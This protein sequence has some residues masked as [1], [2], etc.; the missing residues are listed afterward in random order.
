MHSFAS[1]FTLPL[2]NPVLIFA[3]VLLIILFAPIIF[4]RLRI[5]Y[6][7]GLIVAGIIVGPNGFNVLLHDSSIELFGTVGLLYIM[8][9]AGVEVDIDDFK[10]NRFK[11]IGY[12]LYAFVIA[13]GIGIV[14]ALY[15]LKFDLITSVLLASMFSSHTLLAYPIVSRYGITKIRAVSITVI[16]TIIT[17]TLSLLTLAVVVGS[18]DGNLDALHWV[19]FIGQFLLFS[20]AILFGFPWVTRQFFKR[21][22]DSVA[23]YIFVLAMLFIAAFGAQ[24][25]GMEGI[26]GAFLAG[27][28][29][30]RL[31]PST[32]ALMNRIDFVGNAI[33]IPFF[34]I[35][36]G[37]IV[38]VRV[39]LQGPNA[40]IVA[41]TMAIGAMMAKFL[42]AW[43][44]QKTF[45]L[46]ADERNLIFGL[47]NAHAAAALAVVVVGRR[48]E[49]FNDD[50]L[51]GTVIMILITC[52]VSS[53]ATERAARKIA[54]QSKRHA[55]AG[56]KSGRILIPVSNPATIER[57]VEFATM[58]RGEK[59][60][61]PLYAL[62]ISDKQSVSEEKWEQG[63][64]ILE[65][66]ASYASASDTELEMVHLAHNSIA[67]GVIKATN[68]LHI[69][70]VVLGLHQNT[71]LANAMFAMRLN[72]LL[73]GSKQTIFVSQL[74][75]P[76]NTVRRIIVAVPARA[77]YEAGFSRWLYRLGNLQKQINAKLI[78]YANRAT[79]DHIEALNQKNETV[80]DIQLMEF[81]IRTGLR[82]LVHEV[83]KDDLFVAVGARATS[84]SHAPIIERLY[85][86]L[87]D[88]FAH[89][90][91]LI[92]YPEPYGSDEEQHKFLIGGK[93][94]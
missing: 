8:F 66:A 43:A 49:L 65:K 51:N 81:D 30:N 2:Q 19:Q 54:A 62:Y 5:P 83:H 23:Q 89:S 70:D 76:I 16:G 41:A 82:A 94:M 87:T 57:L 55:T 10:N 6:I 67:K 47:S 92:I 34:L 11:S 7:V 45:N 3:V 50:V 90:N 88:H 39:F 61:E 21:N 79:I 13:L 18:K 59:S 9:L 44:T 93:K 37:M 20:A 25:I 91:L 24:L 38:D 46:R 84:V 17:D 85:A 27:I 48:I 15:V 1:Y 78:F 12:G 35:S 71:D 86:I 75:Q 72:T 56:R 69:T 31:I 63:K 32:S 40:L 36:V 77:E 4:T 74:H 58:I 64:R 80:F 73:K 29:L 28:A 60:K 52:I 53:F 22:T 68:T 14:L 26:I 42:A 33:F